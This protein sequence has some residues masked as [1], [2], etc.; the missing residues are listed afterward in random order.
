MDKVVE[1]LEGGVRSAG[2]GVDGFDGAIEIFES[3]GDVV[4][5]RFAME[6]LWHVPFVSRFGAMRGDEEF[7]QFRFE[8]RAHVL[9]QE[10]V[11]AKDGGRNDYIRVHRPV[12]QFEAAGKNLAPAF[13]FAAG[14]FVADQHCRIDFFEEFLERVVRMP[15]KDKAD[16][17]LL[18]VFFY[19]AQALLEEV[20]VAEVGV[21]VI[22]NDGKEDNNGQAE[23][24]GRIDGDVESR[25]FVDAHGALHPVDDA[26]GIGSGRT[27]AADENAAIFGEFRERFGM[28]DSFC[29]STRRLCG[30]FHSL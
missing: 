7:R 26:F 12:G 10:V 4:R 19:V 16:A 20:V 8:V 28:V 17:S 25:I 29:H 24:V 13:G 23:Q 2:K 22:G 14:V 21:G 27:V 9:E 5:E 6:R 1:A 15:A 18:C 11:A 30:L 3:G